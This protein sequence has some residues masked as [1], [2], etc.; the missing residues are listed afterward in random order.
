VRALEQDGTMTP[1]QAAEY[2]HLHRDTVRRL[3]RQGTLP[4]RKVG[5]QWRIRKHDLDAY[6]SGGKPNGKANS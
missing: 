6:L 2:L 5:K 1:D 4:G 3:L